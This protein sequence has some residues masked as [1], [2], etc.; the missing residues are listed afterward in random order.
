MTIMPK[1]L[2]GFTLVEMAIVLVIIGLILGG[3]V[4]PLTTQ[5]DMQSYSTTRQRLEDAKEALIGYAMTNGRLPCPA[6]ATS[7]GVEDP[8]GGGA[9]N[10]NYDGFL[11]AVTLGLAPVDSNGY[12]LDGW[13]G[14]AANRIRY[15][16]SR[17]STA[18]A[19]AFTTG[20]GMKNQGLAGL[21]P[22]L[23]VCASSN[24]INANDCGTATFLTGSALSAV[25][26]GVGVPVVVYSLGKNAATGGVGLDEAANLNNDQ[27]FV[28]HDPQ[29]SAANGGEFDDIVTWI[30]PNVLYSRMISAGQLP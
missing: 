13:G 3:L 25:P 19:N 6:S 30:S 1:H 15:A 2:R 22:D 21:K 24:G 23:Y 9:C 20:S 18:T 26:P 29:P 28:S 7:N 17:N 10:H 4:L 12:A 16:V 14:I 27:V 8:V 5:R 11:P